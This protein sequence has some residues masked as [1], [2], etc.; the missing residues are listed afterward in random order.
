MKKVEAIIR[1]SKFE[2]VHAKLT[3][4]GIGFM[5][6]SEVKGIGT[7]HAA[8]QQYRGT[9]YDLG[10]IPR[11]LLGIVVHDDKL[12]SLIEAL[13][14]SASTGNIGDGKIFVSDIEQAYRIRNKEKGEDAL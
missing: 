5:T 6:F 4:L 9:E 10:F 7:E 8:I 11:T 3:E 13:L 2:E 12:D 1:T 14:D